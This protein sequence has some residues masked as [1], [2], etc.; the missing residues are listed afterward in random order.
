LASERA[1]FV[2]IWYLT[3][4]K[5]LVKIAYSIDLLAAVLDGSVAAATQVRDDGAAAWL[6]ADADPRIAPLLARRAQ[7]TGGYWLFVALTV[8]LFVLLLASLFSGGVHG[9]LTLLDFGFLVMML[10]QS[11]EAARE[12]IALTR[13]RQVLL[14]LGSVASA[15]LGL[16]VVGA[17]VELGQLMLFP[18]LPEDSDWLAIPL[19][20]GMVL[21]FVALSELLWNRWTPYGRTGLTMTQSGHPAAVRAA[22]SLAKA[23]RIKGLIGVDGCRTQVSPDGD[24]YAGKTKGGKCE[25]HGVYVWASGARHEGEWQKGKRHGHGVTVTPDGTET[26]GRWQ[27]DERVPGG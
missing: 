7:M 10:Q 6:A 8:L 17:L 9:W 22:Q 4:N 11:F 1:P 5:S 19:F 25:G 18:T 2:P 3:A 26:A 16:A 14:Y 15:L 27:D 12:S 20:I 23:A 24:R 13:G 21:I